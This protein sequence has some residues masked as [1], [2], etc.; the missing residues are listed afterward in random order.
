MNRGPTKKV[1]ETL[2]RKTEFQ[3]SLYRSLRE[4]QEGKIKGNSTA[5]GHLSQELTGLYD[6]IN[7]A[8]E[9][10]DAV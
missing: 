8:A 5:V 3:E 7:A 10:L 6:R 9:K 1:C 2:R 4:F